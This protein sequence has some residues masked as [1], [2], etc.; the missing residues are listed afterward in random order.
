MPEVGLGIGRFQRVIGGLQREVLYWYDKQGNRYLAT[1][2]RE[3][4]ALQQM[5]MERQR[6]QQ[7]RQRAQQE[8]QNREALIE[9]LKAR[10]VNLDDLL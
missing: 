1:D 6:A 5:E 4:Q 10:G 2:E 9:R 8:R 7:E 3:Q